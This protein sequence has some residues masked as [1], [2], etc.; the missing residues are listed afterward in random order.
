MGKKHILASEEVDRSSAKN[1]H[2]RS[3]PPIRLDSHTFSTPMG[4]RDTDTLSNRSGVSTIR[5]NELDAMI[6]ETASSKLS[7]LDASSR[8]HRL[9]PSE[10]AGELHAEHNQTGQAARGRPSSAFSQ[11]SL[12]ADA[13][14]NFAHRFAADMSRL[15]ARG[16]GPSPRLSTQLNPIGKARQTNI[17]RGGSV[18]LPREASRALSVEP[19]RVSYT[20][21]NARSTLPANTS[22]MQVSALPH[23]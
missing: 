13:S 20:L 2:S 14:D 23:A 17:T 10:S 8:T 4:K 22:F 21:S 18:A 15:L 19:H 11:G 1:R 7:C 9:S 16:G 5:L 12:A 6:A 3:P